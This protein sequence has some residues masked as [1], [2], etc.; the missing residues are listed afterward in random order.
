MYACQG[1]PDAA[2]FMFLLCLVHL[3]VSLRCHEPV[4]CRPL[5]DW[6]SMDAR[7]RRQ[8]DIRILEN[9]MG[10]KVIGTGGGGLDEL[11]AMDL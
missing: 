3:D 11:D 4:Q 2:P 7:A 8:P 1:L 9:W 10:R 6:G 5:G